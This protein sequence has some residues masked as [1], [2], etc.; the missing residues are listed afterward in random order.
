MV[1]PKVTVRKRDTSHVGGETV[2]E[3]IFPDGRGGLISFRPSD[4]SHPD[5]IEFYRCDSGLRVV[6][7]P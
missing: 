2:V 1:S 6:T 4:G 5:T 3:F 7:Q